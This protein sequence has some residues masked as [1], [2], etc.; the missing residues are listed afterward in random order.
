MTHHIRWAVS[1]GIAC[2]TATMLSAQTPSVPQTP[3]RPTPDAT[4]PTPARTE[5]HPGSI[6]ITGC[7]KMEKD[8]PGLTPNVAERAGVG[9]DFILINAKP[10]ATPSG[11]GAA[12]ALMYRIEGLSSDELKKHVNHQVELQGVVEDEDRATAPPAGTTRGTGDPSRPGATA[13]PPSSAPGAMKDS[14]TAKPK[15]FRAA[16]L[17]MVSATCP[18]GTF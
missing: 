16:S 11:S 2:S 6:T 18:S 15:D 13:T 12:R 9:E 14:D 7:L 4:Q 10:A 5:A 1:F 3:P 17:K 8:V